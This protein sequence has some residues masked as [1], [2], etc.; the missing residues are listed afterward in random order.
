MLVPASKE[1]DTNW[2]AGLRAFR[3][4]HDSARRAYEHALA[5]YRAAH[6][7]ERPAFVAQRPASKSGLERYT[8]TEDTESGARM[9][10]NQQP[11]PGAWVAASS[12][13]ADASR[14]VADA[15]RRVHM[16]R[17]VHLGSA[18]AL[19]KKHATATA[20]A[21]VMGCYKIE[22]VSAERSYVFVNYGDRY[23]IRELG[24]HGGPVRADFSSVIAEW[25][26]ADRRHS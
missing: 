15:E 9:W 16:V 25:P 26:F 13:A 2:Q 7:M 18:V 23:W 6:T 5:S 14:A 24:L 22:D 3:E 19:I 11:P 10:S 20:A 12:G 1:F 8:V 21:D 17:D 4:D